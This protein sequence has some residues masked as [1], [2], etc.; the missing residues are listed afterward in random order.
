MTDRRR[1]VSV[2]QPVLGFNALSLWPDGSGVQTYIVELLG[3]LQSEVDAKLVAAVSEDAVD[4][5][6]DM[7]TA[8]P[9]RRHH[10]IRQ[11]MAEAR[12]IAPADLV[13]GLDVHIPARSPVPTVAT[14]HDLA[15]YDVPWAFKGRWV[16]RERAALAHAVRRADAVVAVSAFTAERIQHLFSR[17]AT[18]VPEAPAPDLA[19]P[20]LRRIAELRARYDLPERF[21]ACVATI[22]PRKDVVGLA[23]ACRSQDIPLVLAGASRLAVP[24]HA[25]HLGYLPREHLAALYGAATVVAYPSLYEGFGLPPLEAMACGAVVVGYRIPP[26]VE[27]LGDTAVLSPPGD[28]VAL[29]KAL[30][31]LMDDDDRR[32]DLRSAGR[33]MAARLSWRATAQA[34]AAVY[35]GLGIDC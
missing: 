18:V 1:D 10:G 34:T 35:R 7:V 17:T 23:A 12:Q 24:A 3:A 27:T 8:L 25:H 2:P 28:V 4:V 26:L 20:S 6:P 16:V 5:L 22:E 15:V 31:S 19:P 14:I 13:H 29:A 9:R 33:S 11:V 21:V 32:E 30:R